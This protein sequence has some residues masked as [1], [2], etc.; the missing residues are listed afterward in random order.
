MDGFKR[1]NKQL[2]SAAPQPVTPRPPETY[3]QRLAGQTP[4]RQAQAPQPAMPQ[5]RPTNSPLPSQ[6]NL[7]GM[8]AVELPDI[9]LDTQPPAPKKRHML[10]NIILGVLACF[11]LAVGAVALW[12]Q[13]SLKPL[14]SSDTT[15]KDFSIE[16]GQTLTD[17]SAN[18]QQKGLIKNQYAFQLYVRLTGQTSMVE[19]NCVLKASEGAEQ[20]AA[21]L[22]KGCSD[23]KSITFYPGATIEKPLY[24]P[25]GAEISQ[26]MMYIKYRLS[27][28]GYTDQQ[29]QAALSSKYSGPLFADKPAGTSLEGYIYGE[30]YHVD[31]TASAEKVLQATFDQMYKDIT[32]NDLVNKFKAQGLN[33]YQGITLSSIVQR[34]LNCEGKLNAQGEIDEVRTQRCYGYQ[35]TIAQVF[36]KRLKEGGVLGSDV[37]FIYAAD[38]LGVVP[39][40]DIESPYNTRINPGL[41][42]GPI[43]SPGLLAMKAV[44]NPSDTE[45][46][47]F[48]AGD[49][50]LMYFAKTQ[51]E[52]EDNIAQHCQVLCNDL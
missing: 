2:Q 51:Q 10:R 31:P 36:L 46:S 9:A 19:S 15:G 28:A 50:G 16:K 4:P 47:Y 38:M 21:K 6:P 29:I 23:Y 35:Q 43:A 49:D 12:Y 32:A 13:D 22:T 11:V 3:E 41:P 14:D 30:T 48:I 17:I 27:N 44:G 5:P 24:K 52:H 33:L 18:L 1:P 26:D 34:E 7:L 20:I 42:P 37:T 40:V 25:A 45:Y 39:R 8:P